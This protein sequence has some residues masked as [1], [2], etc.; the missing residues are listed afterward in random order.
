MPGQRFSLFASFQLPESPDLPFSSFCF[1]TV[2]MYALA[3][4]MGTEGTFVEAPALP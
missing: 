3:M 1:P 4:G 2:D